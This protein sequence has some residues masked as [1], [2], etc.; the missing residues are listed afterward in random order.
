[1]S[2]T[3]ANRH[4]LSWYI[5]SICN[6]RC[7]YC[8]DC[9]TG[10][11]PVW[12]VGSIVNTLTAT[13]KKWCIGI[14]GGE[15]FTYPGF[16]SICKKLTDAD[17]R[18]QIDTNLSL[19]KPVTDFIRTIPQSHVESFYISLH[20]E[21]REAHNGT[22]QFIDHINTLKKH[23]FSFTVNYVLDPRL[24]YRFEKDVLF[25][26]RQ[27]ILLHAKPYRGIYRG[28]LYPEAYT[29]NER[30]LIKNSNPD[31]FRET[32]FYSR[33]ITCAA[34]QQ[35]IRLWP[36][37]TISRCVADK[38]PMGNLTNG[39]SLNKNP[40]PCKMPYCSCFGMDLIS[41]GERNDVLRNRLCGNP[42]LMIT[43]RR[44]GGFFRRS[45]RKHFATI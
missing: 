23:G 22:H 33:G 43:L 40:T 6:Y 15:P 28:R 18:I 29:Q 7:S 2:T 8:G 44:Y 35:M 13:E 31:A 34:G 21:Q 25:F 9:R 36:D 38:T 17:I 32:L 12:D 26:E 1:M 4:F 37:G 45:L 41:N 5:T 11:Q 42:P 39:V 24:L 3:T 10:M 30:T 19:H 27:G 20:I 16:V 14:T